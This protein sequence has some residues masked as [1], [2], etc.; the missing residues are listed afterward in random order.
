MA[1]ISAFFAAVTLAFF[2]VL[3]FMAVLAALVV[4]VFFQEGGLIASTLL[5]FLVVEVLSSSG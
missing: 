5:A 1:T 3:G 4:L 2:V